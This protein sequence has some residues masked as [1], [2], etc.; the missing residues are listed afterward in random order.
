M[1]RRGDGIAR[2]GGEPGGSAEAERRA[3]DGA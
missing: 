3:N 1:A 2:R